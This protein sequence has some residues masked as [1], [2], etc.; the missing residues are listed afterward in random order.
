LLKLVNAT[1][2]CDGPFHTHPSFAGYSPV[3][4]FMH[5]GHVHG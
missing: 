5:A 3:F 2:L 4:N 1:V